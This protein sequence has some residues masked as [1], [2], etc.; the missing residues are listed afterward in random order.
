MVD[1]I[2]NWYYKVRQLLQNETGNSYEKFIAKCDRGLLQSVSGIATYDKSLLQNA[3]GITKCERLLLQSASVTTKCDRL[4]LQSVA[5]ITKW[6]VTRQV[7]TYYKWWQ[8]HDTG[9]IIKTDNSLRKY[10]HLFSR[11]FKVLCFVFCLVI[12]RLFMVK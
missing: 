9:S 12:V 2:K 4:L 7:K 11:V 10:K 1:H 6:D 3:L 8:S 5:V